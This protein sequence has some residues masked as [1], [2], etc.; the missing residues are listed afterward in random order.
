MIIMETFLAI[1][2]ECVGCS[3]GDISTPCSVAV[4]DLHENELVN[5]MINCTDVTD[6]RTN[7]TGLEV[8]SLSGGIS[9]EDARKQVLGHLGPKV[10]LVGQSIEN[11]IA[12]LKVRL[13][14]LTSACRFCF[15]LLFD[16]VVSVAR[17]RNA[18]SQSN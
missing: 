4:T 15:D 8:G 2:V 12:W 18:L 9:F 5:C 13:Y 16:V 3:A 11:D 7:I 10:I 1:D 6:Y 14:V 17:A